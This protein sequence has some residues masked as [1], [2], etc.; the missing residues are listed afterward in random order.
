[1]GTVPAALSAAGGDAEGR[2]FHQVRLPA[3]SASK[4]TAAIVQGHF[5]LLALATV[6]LPD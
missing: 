3:S 1:L 5:R 2:N 4:M 6:A